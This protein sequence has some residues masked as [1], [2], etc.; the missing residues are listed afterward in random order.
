MAAGVHIRRPFSVLSAWLCANAGGVCSRLLFGLVCTEHIRE[1]P[2]RG[3]EMMH[4]F[5][6]R[7]SRSDGVFNQFETEEDEGSTSEPRKIAGPASKTD[8]K[9]QSIV[10]SDSDSLELD[11]DS[12]SKKKHALHRKTLAAKR[13][14]ARMTEEEQLALAVKISQQEQASQVK[15]RQEEDELLRKAIEES[16]HGCKSPEKSATVTVYDITEEA[17]PC[18]KDITLDEQHEE[19]L[20]QQSQVS[21]KDS[22]LNPKVLLNRL[23]QDIVESPSSTR[24]DF[25]NV[26]PSKASLSPVFPV[27][28]P[29]ARKMIPCRLFQDT[30]PSAI[31][32]SDEMEGCSLHRSKSTQPD[33]SSLLSISN[34]SEFKEGACSSHYISACLKESSISKVSVNNKNALSQH[35]SQNSTHNFARKQ[36]NDRSVHYYWGIPFCPNGEDPD[37]YTQVILCQLDV[38]EKSLKKSQR[39]LLQKT[40]YGEPI[41]LSASSERN[42]QAK[43]SQDNLS[44]EDTEEILEGGEQQKPQENFMEP[45][46]DTDGSDIQPVPSKRLKASCSQFQEDEH[47]C[48]SEGQGKSQSRVSSDYF[49]LKLF[50]LF[51][52]IYS[53]WS[54]KKYKFSYMDI[55]NI[56]YVFFFNQSIFNAIECF[57]FFF[58]FLDAFYIS[59]FSLKCSQIFFL[60]KLKLYFWPALVL[61]LVVEEL[62]LCKK[63]SSKDLYISYMNKVYDIPG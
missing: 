17:S 39:Q 9:E 50:V 30:S 23:S 10:I 31:R 19:H 37:A 15:N 62:K 57:F 21:H 47:S 52:L 20:S 8:G 41:D 63:K 43:Y 42:E 27:K 32:L 24:D 4:R 56:K 12:M 28:S 61:P 49:L 3:G 59:Q 33:S 44:Q 51:C 11:E 25:A 26:S 5:R 48:T 45:S 46:E 40:E 22:S 6:K 13:K 60:L 14:I 2:V 35:T 1:L 54:V 55:I 53:F 36:E 34:K 58:F 29:Y 38:Y 16:L 7:K 18:K